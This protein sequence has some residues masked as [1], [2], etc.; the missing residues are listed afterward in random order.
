MQPQGSREG[1]VVPSMSITSEC[2]ESVRMKGSTSLGYLQ[3]GICLIH[4]HPSSGPISR[5]SQ[6]STFKKNLL[7]FCTAAT[8][9]RA[10][11]CYLTTTTAKNLYMLPVRPPI[12]APAIHVCH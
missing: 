8:R 1:F 11:T 5:D 2:G 6:A 10:V 9:C 12:Q 3:Y 7:L 4:T